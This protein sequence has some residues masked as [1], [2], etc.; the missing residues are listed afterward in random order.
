MSASGLSVL[1]WAWGSTVQQGRTFSR[2][3]A[4]LRNC[5]KQREKQCPLTFALSPTPN[6][7]LDS[8]QTGT[9]M[10][11]Q[12]SS[13]P[14][15]SLLY[16]FPLFWNSFCSRPS[17]LPLISGC[18]VPTYSLRWQVTDFLF[19]R[20]T[21][22]LSTVTF[23]GRDYSLVHILFIRHSVDSYCLLKSTN[24]LWSSYVLLYP[25]KCKHSA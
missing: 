2:G 23:Q 19:M 6:P 15:C 18:H 22:M 3:T 14:I 10:E 17:F 13:A 21:L 1:L 11:F 25:S 9:T 4:W 12:V 20:A 16:T 8:S 5:G 24:S 7:L